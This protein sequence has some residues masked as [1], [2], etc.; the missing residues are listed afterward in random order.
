MPRLLATMTSLMVA[1]SFALPCDAVE[2]PARYVDPM[3]GTNAAGHTFPGPCMPFGMVQLSPDNGENGWDYCGGYH[4][5]SKQIVGFSHTH[6]SGTGWGDLSDISFM[7]TTR[8]PDDAWFKAGAKNIEALRTPF[9]HADEQAAP[10][11]YKVALGGDG[12]TVELG[13]SI[14]AGWHRYTFPVGKPRNVVI[15]LGYALDVGRDRPTETGI[16]QTG[17]NTVTGFRFSTGW[18][19]NQKVYFAARFAEPIV[20]LRTWLGTTADGVTTG[21]EIKAVLGFSA[22]DR[23]L[24]IKVALSSVSETNALANLAVEQNDFDFDAQ[25]A[26]SRAA[27]N[28]LFST[29]TIETPDADQKKI[30]YTALYHASIHPSTFSDIDGRSKGFKHQPVTNAGFTTY[31]I[32]SLWDTFRAQMPLLELTRPMVTNDTIKSG[33]SQFRQTGQLPIWELVGNETGSMIGH[34]AIPVI[35][36]A[37]LKGIGDFDKAE[38]WAALVAA[39][40]DTRQGGKVYQEQGWIPCDK[41]RVALCKVLE[42]C[43]NDWCVA[44]VA[45]ALGKN[46]EYAAFLKRSKNWQNVF[47]P[48]SGF[49]RPKRSDGTWLEP[50]DPLKYHGPTVQA[51][52]VEGNAWQWLWFVPHDPDG[53]IKALGGKNAFVTKLDALFHD[54]VGGKYAHHDVSVMIGLYSPGAEQA[55]QAPYLFNFASRPDRTQALV[56]QILTEAYTTKPDGISGNDDCGQLSA[57]YIFSALG[58][59]PVDPVSGE[60]QLG[61]PLYPK[62]TLNLPTG[63]QFTVLADNNSATNPYVQRVSLNGQ[64]LNRTHIT[65]QELMDGGTLRFIMGAQPRKR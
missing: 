10:G 21:K 1:I 5:K 18:A 57:W 29:I 26:R 32:L 30:F 23:P 28:K 34:H 42:Y 58:F 27:W 56:R 50:F 54:P 35:A 65:Y 8:D 45:K 4:Y 11:Y 47:D 14:R 25:V 41:E 63:K 17:A 9:S 59:Y 44:Q 31:T 64:V 48:T 13:A 55:Q 20:G 22:S 39:A 3:I 61:S 49:F 51:H 15:D 60:Y 24:L 6:I 19:A 37:M 43:Y 52:F 7:P 53:L 40:N 38:A 16:R 46:E 36:S 33:L 62:A 2:D 12:I